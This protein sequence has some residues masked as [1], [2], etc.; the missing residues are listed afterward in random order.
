MLQANNEKGNAM[1]IQGSSGVAL[2]LMVKSA[3]M[4][5]NQQKQEGQAVLELLESAQ[6]VSMPSTASVGSSVNTYA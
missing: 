4:A 2:S 3:Q 6:S 5:N 1:D